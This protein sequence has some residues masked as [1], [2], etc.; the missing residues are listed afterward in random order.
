MIVMGTGSASLSSRLSGE[1]QKHTYGTVGSLLD[2]EGCELGRAIHG[3]GRVQGGGG[4]AGWV[5]LRAGTQGGVC[6]RKKAQ[7]DV[8]CSSSSVCPSLPR[9]V[10]PQH[11][12]FCLLAAALCVCFI[13]SCV[14][15]L[16]ISLF[17]LGLMISFLISH[18]RISPTAPFAFLAL[19]F[20]LFPISHL[21]P[22]V[23]LFCLFFLSL[24]SQD[25][26]LFVYL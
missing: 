6:R 8:H 5:G 4:Q 21:S 10:S 16:P 26:Y 22:C 14:F 11:P 20:S 25:I 7:T 23:P 2:G 18:S 15:S 24:F 12:S 9:L 17:C 3:V 13:F 19:T 1:T